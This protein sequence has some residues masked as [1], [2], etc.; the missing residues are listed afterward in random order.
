[1]YFLIDTIECEDHVTGAVIVFTDF[2][3]RSAALGDSVPEEPEILFW[4]NL[5]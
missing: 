3:K 2:H 1:M 4:S 5:R